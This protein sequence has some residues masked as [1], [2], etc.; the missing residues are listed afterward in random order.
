MP[1]TQVETVLTTPNDVLI[2]KPTT[3]NMVSIVKKPPT[4]PKE[5]APVDACS[6]LL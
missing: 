2:G 3:V 5:L 6:S 4:A 1:P